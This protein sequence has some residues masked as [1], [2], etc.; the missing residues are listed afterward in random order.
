MTH[1]AITPDNLSEAATS[2]SQYCGK[3]AKGKARVGAIREAM[4]R[5]MGY[6]DS[7]IALANKGAPKNSQ[8]TPIAFIMHY[9][10]IPTVHASA[11]SLAADIYTE[12]TASEID[13]DSLSVKVD[14]AEEC[15]IPVVYISDNSE[16]DRWSTAG[17]G[18][19]AYPLISIQ[20]IPMYHTNTLKP[21]T[22]YQR[23]SFEH[24]DSGNFLMALAQIMDTNTLTEGTQAE[25]FAIIHTP[26]GEQ[27]RDGFTSRPMAMQWLKDNLVSL[28]PASLEEYAV[29]RCESEDEEDDDLSPED[30]HPPVDIFSTEQ[31]EDT[32]DT[33]RHS[34]RMALFESDYAPLIQHERDSIAAVP[35]IR[36][37][38]N[39][40]VR[41]LT[42]AYV[43]NRDLAVNIDFK[44]AH[45]LWN[46]L[47]AAF[48][49]GNKMPETIKALLSSN[50]VNATPSTLIDRWKPMLDR[51][52]HFIDSL[53]VRMKNEPGVGK[54]ANHIGSNPAG[55]NAY[56]YCDHC[57]LEL[58]GED[59]CYV[60][61]GNEYA[62]GEHSPC[63]RCGEE[64]A[65]ERDSTE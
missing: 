50:I 33:V 47:E 58:H 7:N 34:A 39:R 55:K 15:E 21:V 19:V 29:E 24:G 64:N 36:Q 3:N 53:K 5:F 10:G 30:L 42:L 6:T 60:A 26:S 54:Y 43:V 28:E 14:L 51:E 38:Y 2:V 1:Q 20:R 57:G 56:Y 31:F 13:I 44:S 49:N 62:N 35:L 11:E 45:K 9:K 65:V 48:I 18:M 52:E 23:E 63:P 17:E 27:V 8:A 25:E 32:G 37:N 46:D 40:T 22:D 4:S 41:A 61:A 12:L 16:Y 59:V